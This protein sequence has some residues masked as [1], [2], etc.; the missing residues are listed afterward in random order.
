MQLKMA[1]NWC[2]SP[3]RTNQ[4]R[5]EKMDSR[6]WPLDDASAIHWPISTETKQLTVKELLWLYT[7]QS[8]ETKIERIEIMEKLQP[9]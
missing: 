3:T 5:K 1:R 9:T 4:Q 7:S 6:Q 8:T 2:F